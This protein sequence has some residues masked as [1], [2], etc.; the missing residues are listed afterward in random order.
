MAEPTDEDSEPPQLKALLAPY[1]S[2]RMICLPVS[3][4][5]GNAK[6]ND[7]SLIEQIAGVA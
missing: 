1:P 3:V 7:P 4:R 2:E 6:S 5:V